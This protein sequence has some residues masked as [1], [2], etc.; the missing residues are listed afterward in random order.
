[1]TVIVCTGC[2]PLGP[3]I[4]SQTTYKYR[5]TRVTSFATVQGSLDGVAAVDGVVGT[6]SLKGMERVS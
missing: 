4:R 5:E 6:Y 1:M 2:D 3:G